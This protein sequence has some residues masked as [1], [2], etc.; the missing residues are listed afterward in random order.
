MQQR[1]GCETPDFLRQ[2]R[3]GR[4]RRFGL[5]K[6]SIEISKKGIELLEKRGYLLGAISDASL[7]LA[8]TALLSDLVLDVA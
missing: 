8:V 2:R 6:V 5:R 4:P 1:P 3:V 7:G